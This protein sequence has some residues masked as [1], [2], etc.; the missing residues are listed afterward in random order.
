MYQGVTEDEK[1][2]LSFLISVD[3]PFL[4]PYLNQ[5]LTTVEEF[6]SFYSNVNTLIDTSAPDQFT[7]PLD[8]L[9]ELV[10][11]IVISEK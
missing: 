4:A 6:E 5:P 11:S 1:Y 8:I 10:S 7:P 3:A 2:F 9:D